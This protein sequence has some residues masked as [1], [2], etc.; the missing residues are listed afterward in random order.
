MAQEET[1]KDTAIPPSVLCNCS[2]GAGG[3][4]VG[5]HMEGF[6]PNGLMPVLAIYLKV[7]YNPTPLTFSVFP[8]KAETTTHQMLFF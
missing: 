7:R 3:G 5:G 2:N 4:G 8:H 6:P 1:F